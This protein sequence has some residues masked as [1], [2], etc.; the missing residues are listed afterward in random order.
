MWRG[1]VWGLEVGLGR[2]EGGGSSHA[3]SFENYCALYEE[4][5]RLC[6]LSPG[7]LWV[8]YLGKCACVE[9]W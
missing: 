5:E 8:A 4:G 1:I 9:H 3:C 7:A 6:F 2:R